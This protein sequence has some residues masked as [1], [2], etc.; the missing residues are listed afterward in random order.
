MVQRLCY[1]LVVFLLMF[2]GEILG[3]E[4]P[5]IF[6]RKPTDRNKIIQETVKKINAGQNKSSY[7]LTGTYKFEGLNDF[8]VNTSPSCFGPNISF[9]VSSISYAKDLG[10]FCKKE[11]QLDKITTI[12]IRFR[13]GSMQYVNWMEQKPNAVKPQ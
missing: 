4:N 8:S 10:W 7:A 1:F 13:L 9:I 3:Q 2:N 11:L 5:H 12:P 6:L